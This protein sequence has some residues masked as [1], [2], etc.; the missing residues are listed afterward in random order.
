MRLLCPLVMEMDD[1][2]KTVDR[3]YTLILDQVKVGVE[4]IK[5]FFF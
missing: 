5:V 4:D 1:K 3:E 2:E